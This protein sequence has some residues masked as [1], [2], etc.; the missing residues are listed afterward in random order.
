MIFMLP[1][2]EVSLAPCEVE[3]NIIDLR[4]IGINCFL[5]LLG[6]IIIDIFGGSIISFVRIFGIG[7]RFKL[8]T[9]IQ[10]SVSMSNSLVLF[11][12]E[13]SRKEVF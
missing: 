3:G 4:L 8:I 1:A 7:L 5:L 6:S 2:A 13:M 12:I 10:R 9:S 11:L